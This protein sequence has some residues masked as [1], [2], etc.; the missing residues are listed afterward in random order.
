MRYMNG[1]ISAMKLLASAGLKG[2]ELLKKA[3]APVRVRVRR[4]IVRIEIEQT[5]V[6][7]RVPI[8]TAIQHIRQNPKPGRTDRTSLIY[9]MFL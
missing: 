3:G 2:I 4:R 1:F 5:I 6:R 7:V 8:A 9:S